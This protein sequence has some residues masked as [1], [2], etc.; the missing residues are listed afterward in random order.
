LQIGPG[1]HPAHCS[2][3]NASICR[4]KK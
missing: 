1:A 3:G 4:G 2:M